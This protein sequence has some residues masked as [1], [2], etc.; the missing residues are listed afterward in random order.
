M[1]CCLDTLYF[2]PENYKGEMS[3]YLLIY[4]YGATFG[5]R[6]IEVS[7]SRVGDTIL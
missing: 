7:D 5:S 4:F 6:Q 2:F 1:E 3:L